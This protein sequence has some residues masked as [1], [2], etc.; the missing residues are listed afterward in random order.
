V[1][2]WKL[3]VTLGEESIRKNGLM[4]CVWVLVLVLVVVSVSVSVLVGGR[5]VG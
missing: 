3:D 2:E 5:N 4:V 1:D